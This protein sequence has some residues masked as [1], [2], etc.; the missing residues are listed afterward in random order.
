M[1]LNIDKYWLRTQV[2]TLVYT[3]HINILGLGLGLTQRINLIDR[4]STT[5]FPIAPYLTQHSHHAPVLLIWWMKFTLV[6]ILMLQHQLVCCEFSLSSRAQSLKDIT[7]WLFRWRSTGSLGG[8]V[9]RDSDGMLTI[10]W[11]FVGL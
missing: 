5:L 9:H 1:W 7:G 6:L 3:V 4:Q 2:Y 11:S 10:T 8:V